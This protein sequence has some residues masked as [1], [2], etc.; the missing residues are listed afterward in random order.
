MGAK[1]YT[2]VMVT[3]QLSHLPVEN[4]P[5]ES[6]TPD[7]LNGCFVRAFG[8]D[9]VEVHTIIH[10]KDTRP[11]WN[12]GM[13]CYDV[14]LKETHFHSVMKFKKPKT[15]NVVAKALM[16]EPQYVEKPKSAG[17]YAYSNMLSYLIHA[18]ENEKH[19]YAPEEVASIGKPYMEYF[20]EYGKQWERG[21]AAKIKGDALLS[22][23]DL[24]LK[25]FQG[26]IK[27]IDQIYL[28][29]DFFR[30]YQFNP[31]PIDKAF[32][33]MGA[34]H[35]FD[36]A[37]MIRKG[38]LFKQC[39]FIYGAP[40][41]G[42]TTIANEL[43]RRFQSEQHYKVCRTAATNMFDEYKGEDILLMDDVRGGGCNAEDW[44]KLLDPCN[45]SP[46]SARYKNKVM[47]PRII[48]IT[49]SKPLYEFFY[50]TKGIR[51]ARAEALDQFVR[52][53]QAMITV[54]DVDMYK[55]AKTK[56][57]ETPVSTYITSKDGDKVY[58][59]MR[60]VIDDESELKNKEELVK[61]VHEII[62]DNQPAN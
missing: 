12:E 18:K 49:S 2:A 59:Q 1:S 48:I 27:S 9:L 19:Q 15:L 54:V 7:W 22:V 58:E 5:I 4:M 52:R 42:K 23:D 13:K 41:A 45:V 25:I 44:L 57:L 21:K 60:Y 43:C 14:E 51:G 28:T 30:V 55:I 47:A 61:L 17:R 6:M 40:G 62:E 8:D 37:E 35:A 31:D 36:T 29:D 56:K 39:F 20:K 11:V 46:A 3:Q 50:Y 16:V 24:R 32:D 53:F 38:Q 33:I 10:D 26:E 34:K